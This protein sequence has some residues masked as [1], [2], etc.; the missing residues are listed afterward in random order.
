MKKKDFNK[1]QIL[2]FC[3]FYSFK[4]Q[5][6]ILND[7]IQKKQIAII[8][9]P[10]KDNSILLRWAATT[11]I[12]WKKS[13]NYGYQI[14]RFTLI[15]DGKTLKIIEEKY[16]GVFKP[17][18][19]NKWMEIIED[20]NNAAIV[21]QSIYGEEFQVQGIDKLSAIVNLSEEQQQRFTWAL[22]A[23]DQDFE[24]AK[25]AGLGYIDS[26]AKPNEK[27]LYKVSS[28]VPSKELEIEEGS[29]FIGLQDYKELPK[30]LDL[31]VTF[32]DQK[33]MLSWNYGIHKKVYN[34]YF[35]ERSEDG[36][37]F[38]RLNDLPLTSLNNS[39]RSSVKR[40]FYID[41]ISNN[42]K[43]YYRIKGRTPFGEISPASDVISGTG[44]KRLAYMPHIT[45]KNY[46]GTS[47]I[48]LEWEFPEEGNK[49]IIGFELNRSDKSKGGYKTLVKNI[50]PEVRKIKYDSLQPSNYMTITAVGK[51]GNRRT[52]FAALVQPVDSI[53]PVKPIGLSGKIDSLG[54]V[55]LN[56]KANIEKDMLGY[57]VFR[58]NTKTEEFS[59]ITVS[60]HNA[61][62][63]YDSISI[64]N[65]NSKVY[66]RIV[67][68]DKRFNGSEFS[69]V[70]ALKKPDVIP[71][72][73]AIFKKY[74]IQDD[75][76]HLTW[77][78]SSSED[79]IKHELYRRSEANKSW[80]VIYVEN[81]IGSKKEPIDKKELSN[82]IDTKVEE[83]EQY[84]YT[85]MA[86]DDSN[87]KSKP[88]PPLTVVIPKTT[89]KPAIKR[90]ASTVDKKHGFIELYW[91]EYKEPNVANLMI[92]KGLKDGKITLM[93]NTLPNIKHIV[94]D[95]VKPNN[96][97]VYMI[98]AIF[99]D[100]TISK[101]IKLNV[102][103]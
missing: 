9:S 37:N 6:Q 73:S 103:Y 78:K 35:I 66:Y 32:L 27:Y 50:P 59:Q 33:A 96:E 74:T 83:G 20:N 7:T 61:T 80:Q 40:M 55:T 67:A 71:P 85:L 86:F 56:W 48:V 70:L 45:N 51:N 94:D 34:S 92:Y 16:L 58:G 18:P 25:M 84:S 99:K 36:E 24:V 38:T 53:P 42:E 17:L 60:P 87:L 63:Y 68:V 5:A 31:A 44:L 76:V 90:L 21:A 11:P 23:A 65:L 52:S 2:I 79:A 72:T 82:W 89:L 22:Y 43:Q 1:I 102:K 19:L 29:V 98:R 97:Y 41:S 62:V 57:R 95:N 39:S 10:Q 3:I 30:P 69:D 12:A 46:F 77:V 8:A 47:G 101:T 13:N 100:G 93:R 88:S 54:V 15:K 14:K 4:I 64:K 75:G 26:S 28:L 91:K 81:L 49:E